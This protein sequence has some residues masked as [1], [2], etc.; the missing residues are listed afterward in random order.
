MFGAFTEFD[1]DFAMLG[2]RLESHVAE[3]RQ[4][5]VGMGRMVSCQAI[6]PL[7]SA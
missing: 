5:R 7:Q 1:K 2:C 6:Y 4:Q 3:F